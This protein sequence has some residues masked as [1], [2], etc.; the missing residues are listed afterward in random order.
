MGGWRGQPDRL[1]LFIRCYTKFSQ[2]SQRLVSLDPC[3]ASFGEDFSDSLKMKKHE[4]CAQSN[5]SNVWQ[6][7]SRF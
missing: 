5:V 7:T 3:R 4:L 2:G 6:S 1:S